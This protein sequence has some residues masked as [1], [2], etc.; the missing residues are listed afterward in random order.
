[1]GIQA[2]VELAGKLDPEKIHGKVIIVKTVCRKEFEER[3]GSIC[4]EDE[5]NLNRVFPGNPLGTRMDRLA[6]EVVLKLHSMADYYIDLHS[7]D[8][9]EQLTPYIYYAGRADE[10]VVKAS[11]KMAEQA[12]VPYM[13]KSNSGSGGSYNYAAACGI[14]SVLLERGGFY[15]KGCAQ[16]SM[17]SWGLR[18]SS[19]LQ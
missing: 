13:V 14:P 16:Y 6:Y 2:A 17:R 11:R 4:P 19:K 7:G 9:Y 18:R 8:D 15:K 1:M 3:S 10:D 5:K 12:D